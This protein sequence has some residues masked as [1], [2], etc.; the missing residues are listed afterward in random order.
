M[1][2][3]KRLD[4][5]TCINGLKW[6]VLD[7]LAEEEAKLLSLYVRLLVIRTNSGIKIN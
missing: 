4:V 3:M 2:S 5:E 1:N 7:V 6:I